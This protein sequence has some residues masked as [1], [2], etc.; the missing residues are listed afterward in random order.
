[1]LDPDELAAVAGR[2]GVSDDQVRRDHLISLLL[3]ALS[4]E[5]AHSLVFIGGTALA[6]TLLTDGRLSEDVDLL[7]IPERGRIVDSVERVLADSARREV[8]RLTWAPSLDERRAEVGGVLRSND[9]LT[10]RVQLLSASDYPPWPT[11]WRDLHQRYSTVPPARLPV[12]TEPAFV[13]A[14]T[15]AWVFR[16]APR[17]LYDLWALGEKGLIDSRARALYCSLGPTGGPPAPV[18]FAD[19]P[20][21]DAWESELAGQTRLTITG[22]HALSVVRSAWADA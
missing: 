20:G 21:D 4:R 14:K 2:F 22:Q 15:V 17:D 19:P 3:A 10:V 8:G 11:E 16:R 6:R 12:L 1:M 9:G 7:A 18:D 13:A 5:M